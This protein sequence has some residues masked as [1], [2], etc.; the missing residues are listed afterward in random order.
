MRLVS[1][2]A[3]RVIEEK[4]ARPLDLSLEGK[5]E[6]LRVGFREHG[7]PSEALRND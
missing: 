1:G 5:R 3:A 7:A 6:R 2:A 4:I